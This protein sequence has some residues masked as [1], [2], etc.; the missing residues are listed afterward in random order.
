MTPAQPHASTVPLTPDEDAARWQ[1]A[2]QLRQQRPGWVV[3]WLARTGQFRAY[4]LFTA[5]PGTTLAAKTPEEL[6]TLM[7]HAEQAARRPK[8]RSRRMDS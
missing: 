8:A 3:I 4:P 5:R 6:G 1:A 7:D 2:K